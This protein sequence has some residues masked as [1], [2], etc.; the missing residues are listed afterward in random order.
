MDFI[1]IYI[2]IYIYIHT[3]LFR[4]GFNINIVSKIKSCYLSKT[5]SILID[6]G[7][8]NPSLIWFYYNNAENYIDYILHP[9]SLK[10]KAKP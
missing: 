6:S 1:Y 8:P 2:Y 9:T 3:S 4:S 7:K 10:A 5:L